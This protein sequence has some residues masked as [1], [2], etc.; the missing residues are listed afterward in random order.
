MILWLTGRTRLYLVEE[1]LVRVLVA[2]R[3][4]GRPP[5]SVT[6]GCSVRNSVL[7]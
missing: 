4:V 3:L 2:A 6:D 5:R 7:A 1:Q